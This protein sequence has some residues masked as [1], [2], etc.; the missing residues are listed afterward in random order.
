[1]SY[2]TAVLTSLEA[3]LLQV[4]ESLESTQRS[5][6]ELP[7]IPS[8]DEMSDSELFYSTYRRHVSL[9]SAVHRT[10]V[11][12]QAISVEFRH[13]RMDTVEPDGYALATIHKFKKEA[14]HMTSLI[15]E[16][17]THLNLMKTDLDYKIKFLANA[18]YL[19]TSPYNIH[20]T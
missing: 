18:S 20:S 12:L 5:Y 15:E 19:L 17:K 14:Q 2:S 11:A 13:Y 10:L 3:T 8:W 6:E 1:M 9:M 7:E 16:M 4:K